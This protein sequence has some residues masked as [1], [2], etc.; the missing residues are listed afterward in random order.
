[1]IIALPD[2]HN[3]EFPD[4]MSQDEIKSVIQKK[5]PAQN[6]ATPQQPPISDRDRLK[7]HFEDAI[8]INKPSIAQDFAG[9]I[10]NAGNSLLQALPNLS[11]M[12][13]A[14]FQNVM[15]EKPMDFDAYKA[16]GTTNQPWNTPR[17]VVQTAGELFMPGKVVE[18]AAPFVGKM[19]STVDNALAKIDPKMAANAIQ[20]THDALQSHASSIFDLVGSEA[21]NRGVDTIPG[22]EDTINKIA[23]GKYLAKTPANNK[24]LDAARA[25]DYSAL[26]DLQSDLWNEATSSVSSRAERRE[27]E[28]MF[29]LRDQINSLVGDHFHN[30]G[31]DDLNKLLQEGTDK[32]RDLKETYFGKYVPRGIKNLVQTGSREV[33][34]NMMKLL[35]RDSDPMRRILQNNSIAAKHAELALNKQN[36]LT[37]LKS[38]GSAGLVTTGI[39]GGTLGT[40]ALYN[41]VVNSLSSQPY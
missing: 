26:R 37:K 5:Y 27:G 6:S 40:A 14:S 3:A 11:T 13:P 15:P 9:G 19:I 21:K 32:W 18:K 38:L 33:P 28:E 2:G 4:N 16:M 31:H 1:M 7:Q 35:Q 10:L 36:A 17:G 30:M 20:A 41:K 25:G 29:D 22:V 12:M 24:L 39:T 34:G 8:G 23:E